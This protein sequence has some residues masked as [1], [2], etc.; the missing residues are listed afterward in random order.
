VTASRESRK[1][2]EDDVDYDDGQ[3]RSRAVGGVDDEDKPDQASTT[4]T[5][6]ND[7]F[8]GRVAGEDVGY[9]EE[10]GAERRQK[11]T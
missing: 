5:T 8:V 4:G 9:A 2:R 6:P 11:A 3:A 1:P 10:T 7:E